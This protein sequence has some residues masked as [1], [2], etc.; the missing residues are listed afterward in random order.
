MLA[1]RPHRG[2]GE[3]FSLPEAKYRVFARGYGLIDSQKVDASRGQRLDLTAVVAP[4]PAAAAEYYPA[5]YWYSMHRIMDAGL[6]VPDRR[7]PPVRKT[8]AGCPSMKAYWDRAPA[9]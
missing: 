3:N 6:A 4:S 9:F 5:V 8:A 2:F 7:I 1:V